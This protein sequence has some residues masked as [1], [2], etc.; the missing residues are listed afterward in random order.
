MKKIILIIFTGLLLNSCGTPAARLNIINA[1]PYGS[2]VEKVCDAKNWNYV[3]KREFPW[4]G[5]GQVI[6]LCTSNS[7][8]EFNK[9]KKTMI[10]VGKN[11]KGGN[12]GGYFVFENVTKPLN[13]NPLFCIYG[14]GR[15]KHVATSLDDARTYADPELLAAYQIE[16]EKK[17]KEEERL[18]KIRA[19]EEE[20]RLNNEKKKC[21]AEI[22]LE[23]SWKYGVSEDN[24]IHNFKSKTD[25][26]IT[27]TSIGL[28]TSNDKI[29]FEKSTEAYIGPYSVRDIA[30]NIG[31]INKDI[32]KYGFYRCRWATTVD[33]QAKPSN[34]YTPPKDTSSGSKDFLK[35]II[36]K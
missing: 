29:V 14:D 27:I 10:I 19:K 18:A 25:K 2:T 6:D 30:V 33:T 35:K 26:P 5:S 7:Y 3:E 34:I 13:C 11:A 16:Q 17:R 24:I 12:A 9:D 23:F 36:G 32:V 21:N 8:V 28:E 20:T 15:F 1:V 22:N 4:A 31:N